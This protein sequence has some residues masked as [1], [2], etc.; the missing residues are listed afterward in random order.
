MILQGKTPT[1]KERSQMEEMRN[2]LGEDWLTALARV[3]Q[4]AVAYQ[5]AKLAADLPEPSEEQEEVLIELL[6]DLEDAVMLLPLKKEE[7]V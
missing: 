1:A 6:V 4:A 2:K 7:S 3:E 5:H